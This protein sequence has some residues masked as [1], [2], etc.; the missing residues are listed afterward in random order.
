[1][2][3]IK[4]GKRKSFNRY[5]RSEKGN[6]SLDECY[7]G[8]IDQTSSD[9][10]YVKFPTKSFEN[11]F[12]FVP[13]FV[14]FY[15]CR[16]IFKRKHGGLD[17]VV[18]KFDEHFFFPTEVQPKAQQLNVEIQDGKLHL[19]GE[20]VKWFNGKLNEKQQ[21]AVQQA[22]RGECRPL[23]FVIFGPPGKHSIDIVL[24]SL[25]FY[26]ISISES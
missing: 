22:L 14:E 16:A 10:L 3:A 24:N 9:R 21:L 5:Q 1:M 19:N 11:E 15:Y 7:R 26:F 13:Y 8:K 25:R 23:P 2:R 18:K 17:A 20:T 4:F 6:L 12:E